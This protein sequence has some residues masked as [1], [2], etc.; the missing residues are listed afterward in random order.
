MQQILEGC[1]Y[2]HQK[3]YIHRDLKTA[4]LLMNNKG[5][6]KICDFGMARYRDPRD[7]KLTRS[8]VTIWYRA[9]E[10]LYGERNYSSKVD[11]WSVGCIMAEVLTKKVLFDGHEEKDQMEKIYQKLGS[12][13]ETWDGCSRLPHYNDMK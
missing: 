11:M 10:L 1:A 7:T 2:L 4:N 12:P 5:E 9:P 6:M 8:C 13:D 3:N